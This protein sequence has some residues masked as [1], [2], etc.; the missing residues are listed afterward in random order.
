MKESLI[1]KVNNLKDE[2]I[3]TMLEK[4]DNLQETYFMPIVLILYENKDEKNQK[5]EIDKDK[6]KSIEP[7]LIF[8]EKYEVSRNFIEE[9]IEP[10]LLRF[11]SIHNKLGD[12]IEINNKES[13]DLKDI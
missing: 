11:C 8:I 12:K 5:I 7:K 10:K 6:Y 13:Y 3:E 1:I 2:I 4:M 9:K